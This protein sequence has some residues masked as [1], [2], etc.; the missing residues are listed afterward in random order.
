MK[1]TFMNPLVIVKDVQLS[2]QFYES[3]LDQ[4]IKFDFGGCQAFQSGLTLQEQSTITTFLHFPDKDIMKD[5]I[6]TILYFETDDFDAFIHKLKEHAQIKY[7]HEIIEYDWGQRSISFYDLDKHPINVSESMP[8]VFKK[9][10]RQGMTIEEVAK[11]TEHPL[12]FVE[13]CL[14]DFND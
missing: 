4:T 9:Y 10:A 5:S 13:E 3:L 2:R 14:K 1:T 8:T 7:I 11:R 6:R 12:D